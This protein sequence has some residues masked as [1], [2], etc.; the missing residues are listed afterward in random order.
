MSKWRPWYDDHS[1]EERP[2]YLAPGVVWPVPGAHTFTAPAQN[3]D[4]P[5]VYDW[6]RDWPEVERSGWTYVR[7]RIMYSHDRKVLRLVFSGEWPDRSLEWG[8]VRV[9][10][11]NVSGRTMQIDIQGVDWND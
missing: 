1:S 4:G 6:K 5:E 3:T 10:R 2:T 9:I 8:G 7:G 11:R